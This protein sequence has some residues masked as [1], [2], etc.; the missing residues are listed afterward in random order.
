VHHRE[1]PLRITKGTVDVGPVWATEI[2][3]A[4]RNKLA[5]GVVEPGAGLD[6]R[7]RITYHVCRL[8]DT[9]NPENAEKFLAFVKSPPAQGIY[10]KYGF[11]PHFPAG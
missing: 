5:V 7:D 11:V 9:A 3:H 4:L 10:A 1:T 6:Q 2:T 8:N